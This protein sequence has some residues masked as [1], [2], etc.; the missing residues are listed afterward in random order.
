M[1]RREGDKMRF[2][3]DKIFFLIGKVV[4]SRF[5]MKRLFWNY[6]GNCFFFFICECFFVRYT[7]REEQT[8][9]NKKKNRRYYLSYLSDLPNRKSSQV[10]KS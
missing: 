4:G 6:S 9:K 5:V 8:T 7:E 2:V 3:M 1:G 10:N